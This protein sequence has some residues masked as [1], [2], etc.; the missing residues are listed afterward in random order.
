MLRAILCILFIL[1][2]FI[3]CGQKQESPEQESKSLSV[4]LTL[5]QIPKS[6]RLYKPTNRNIQIALKNA[7]FYKGKIDG[8]IG[9]LSLKAIREFQAENNLI[10]DGKIGSRTWVV[11]REYLGENKE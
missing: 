1:S 7:G 11:L 6:F 4:E 9:S 5:P 2:F 10:V 3:G 8:D